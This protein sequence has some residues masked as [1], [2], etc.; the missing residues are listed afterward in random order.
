MPLRS[1]F[2][3]V[4]E[5]K[6]DII[7]CVDR[8]EVDQPAPKVD[9]ELLHQAILCPQGFQKGFDLGFPCLLVGDGFADR[10]VPSLGGIIPSGQPIVPLWYSTWSRATWAFS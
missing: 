5:G 9:I 8:Y 4:L 2:T 7:L 1:D 10:I 3:A 6:A